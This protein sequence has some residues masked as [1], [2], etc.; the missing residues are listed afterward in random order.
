MKGMDTTLQWNEWSWIKT[1]N[2]V[3]IDNPAGIGYSI[4]E[5]DGC[6]NNDNQTGVDNLLMLEK[7]YE[8]F[9]ELK[10]NDLYL[11]GESYAGIYVPQFAKNV[12]LNNQDPKTDNY[13]LKGIM[14]GNGVTNW[15]Y[16]TTPAS[17]KFAY[18]RGLIDTET[19][20][21]SIK[22]GCDYS[23]V[24]PLNTSSSPVE[25]DNL[26]ARWGQLVEKLDVYN[27]YA[28]CW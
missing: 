6:K 1:N 8:R 25:C 16:D 27:V 10:T 13:T 23:K 18:Q 7:F 3:W 20:M 26:V 14:V 5:K 11:S 17:M 21:N 12:H 9:P 22:W 2:V 19:H 15:T 28:K 24:A 4:C